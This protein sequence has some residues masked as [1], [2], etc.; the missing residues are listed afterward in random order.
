MALQVG[1]GGPLQPPS[2][3]PGDA[4][5][6]RPEEG[7]APSLDLDE[8]DDVT[9]GCDDVD[10][11]FRRSPIGVEDGET[12]AF[13]ESPGPRLADPSDGFV[14][15]EAR[16]ISRFHRRSQRLSR[17]RSLWADSQR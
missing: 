12:G 4:F 17:G 9:V 5:L 7:P 8:D 10:L 3:L 16:S 15:Q 11:P 13:Q 2:F 6:R 1:Q 14:H